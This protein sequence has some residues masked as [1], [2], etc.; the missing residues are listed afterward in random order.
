P[1]GYFKGQDITIRSVSDGKI[2]MMCARKVLVVLDDIDHIDQLE[3]LADKEAICLFSRYAFG[4][5]IHIKGY[6]E[7]SEQV[8]CYTRGLPLTIK[9]L[10]SFL[11]GKDEL[12]WKDA[13]ERLKTIPLKE[14]L[15]KLELSY[16]SLE[17]DY[18][19]IFLDVACVLKR[20]NKDEAITAL[21]CCGFHARNGKNIVR[22]LHPTKPNKHSRLWINE[23][24][25]YILAND[26]GTEDTTCISVYTDGFKSFEVQMKGLANMKELRFLDL[27]TAEVL[28]KLKFLSIHL[29]L[30][31]TLDLR[32]APNVKT[33]CLVD[34]FFLEDL[35][36]PVESPKLKSLH[37]D[38]TNLMIL[39]LR[40]TKNLKNLSLKFFEHLVELHMPAE[41]LKL[42]S[43]GSIS[44]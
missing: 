6:K 5:E 2:K 39:N 35:H 17:D 12:E 38:N 37:L 22:R 36:M 4:K 34:K 18:K 42:K 44:L 26:L 30:L 10:G 27:Y 19:E 24:I 20:W 31:G 25:N 8:S 16:N 28:S 11:C 13:I 43:V 41:C 40:I 21:E 7:L 14:T 23:E 1:F 29:S 9:V 32:L 33:V 15:Q 3:A